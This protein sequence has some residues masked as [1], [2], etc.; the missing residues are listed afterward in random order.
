MAPIETGSAVPLEPPWLEA[1]LLQLAVALERGHRLVFGVSLLPMAERSPRL[2]AQE[3]FAGA[4]VLLA[5]DGSA[6]PRLVYAN[7]AALRWWRPAH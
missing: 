3:L 2:L 7:R 6:D 1:P 4:E 5:H